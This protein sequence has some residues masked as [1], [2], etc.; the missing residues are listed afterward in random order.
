MNNNKRFVPTPPNYKGE[1]V[2]VWVGI[3]KNNNQYLKI[4][5]LGNINLMAFKYQPKE[6]E[7]AV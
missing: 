1:G 2:S 5:I 7:G 6:K 3:D 4:K